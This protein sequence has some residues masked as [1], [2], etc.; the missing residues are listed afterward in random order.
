ML[1]RTNLPSFI[2]T[3]GTFLM[4][5]GLNLGFTKLISGTVSTKS[6]S[7]M[8]GFSSAEGRLRLAR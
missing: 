5:T 8:E 2:I 6:I 1:T 7:D 3:L 4:L